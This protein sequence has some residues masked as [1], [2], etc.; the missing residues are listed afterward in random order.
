MK[1]KHTQSLIAISLLSATL[2][3][4]GCG[5]SS[6]NDATAVTTGQFVDNYVANVDYSCADGSHGITDVN[7]SFNCK[8]LPVTFT[9]G[10]LKLGTITTMPKDRQ[11]FPQDLFDLN[12]SDVNNSAVVAMAQFLQSCD[13]DANAQNGIHIK[14]SLKTT[15]QD[16]NITFNADDVDAYAADAHIELIHKDEAIKHLQHTVEFVEDLDKSEVPNHVKETLFSPVSTLTQDA[17]NTLS[18][19][20]NE[21][22]LAHDVY[23]ELYQYHLQNDKEAI[24]QLENITKAET[25]HIQT[26]QALVNKYDLNIS[27][28]TNIDLTPLDNEDATVAQMPIGKYDIQSI[29]DLHDSLIA[30]GEQSKQDALEVGCMVEVT[31]ITDLTK[32]IATA[33][34][35]N[36]SDVVSAFEFLRQGSY[37]HYW[38][39]DKGLKN[40]GVED[41]CCV[42][43]TEYCHPEY[44]QNAKGNAQNDKENAKGNAQNDKENAK[45][46]AQNDKENAKSNAQEQ[47]DENKSAH[48][49][50]Q[51]N[52]S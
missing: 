6:S 39:F 19:M 20:G 23:T 46:N 15:F 9:I 32:D 41:G 51:K 30:K 13:D 35:S 29:Q 40:M 38:A 10:G 43:G 37:S 33:Q 8:T 4:S 44:P 45:S 28:F 1:R 12:R 34:E 49:N 2:L 52:R 36:A 18:Y 48:Q 25:T 47:R 50:E 22:R 11:V 14:A 17:K 7:G 31:D 21:E 27:S 42:L 16:T 5:S 3:I 24:K 26:V